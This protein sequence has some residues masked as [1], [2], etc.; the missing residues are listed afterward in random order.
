MESRHGAEDE[1]QPDP[2][3]EGSGMNVNRSSQRRRLPEDELKLLN[4][5]SDYPHLAAMLEAEAVLRSAQRKEKTSEAEKNAA[6]PA[7][8]SQT[9]VRFSFLSS[10]FF[11]CFKITFGNFS[12]GLSWVIS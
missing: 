6:E 2:K 7:S 1:P 4:D 12:S 11:V 3:E 9:D 5:L 8:L 10:F